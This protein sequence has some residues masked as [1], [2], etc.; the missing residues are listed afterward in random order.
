MKL[1]SKFS[2][3]SKEEGSAQ[4]EKSNDLTQDVVKYLGRTRQSASIGDFSDFSTNV[5][6]GVD[7]FSITVENIMLKEDVKAFIFRGDKNKT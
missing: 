5:A 3:F 2:H 4:E 6:E 1:K 7:D